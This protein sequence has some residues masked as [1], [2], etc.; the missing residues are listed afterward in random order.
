MKLVGA[1]LDGRV[2]HG[3]SRPAVF[4][5]EARCLDLELLNGIDGRQNNKIRSIEEVDGIG[6]IVD[7]I[8]HV[9]VLRGPIAVRGESAAGRIAASI[10]LWSIYSSRKLR[11]ES[12]VSAVERKIVHAALVDHLTD[13]SVLTLQH[14]SSGGHFD[15]FA[16]GARVCSLKLAS[17]LSR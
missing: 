3:S 2:E 8:E 10:G 17:T 12:E 16:D 5:A 13:R 15:G 7:A 4:R 9:I 11:E 14:R 1:G 6:I